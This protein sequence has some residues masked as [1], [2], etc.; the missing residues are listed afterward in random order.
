[1][2]LSH[3][4]TCKVDP[5]NHTAHTRDRLKSA[6]GTKNL[7]RGVTA[8]NKRRSVKEDGSATIGSQQSLHQAVSKYTPHR[9]RAII[10]MRCARSNRPFEFVN[11]EFYA[12]EVE[13]LRPGTKIPDPR[14][15]SRDVNKLYNELSKNVKT[16]FAVS[17]RASLVTCY[18]LPMVTLIGL[19]WQDPSRNGWVD[20]ASTLFL[21]RD[22]NCLVCTQ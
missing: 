18:D 16:Y 6:T 17:G 20:I 9:H 10:A 4:F 1:M 8:C 5:I 15:V 22:R 21:P 19:Q 13:L 14:T 2:K 3:V 11:D 7:D 12:H